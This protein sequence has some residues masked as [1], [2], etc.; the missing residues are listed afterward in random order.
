MLLER[1]G[2]AQWQWVKESYSYRLHF[3]YPGQ[4]LLPGWGYGYSMPGPNDGM[5][6]QLGVPIFLLAVLGAGAALFG[7][8]GGRLKDGA[9][10]GPAR[11]GAGR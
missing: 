3:V 7:G 10:A 8:S 1:G 4:F 2:V 11:D 9:G 5:S 6:F